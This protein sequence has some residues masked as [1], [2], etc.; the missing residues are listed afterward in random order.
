QTVG[1]C[2]PQQEGSFPSEFRKEGDAYE[3]HNIV[4]FIPIH[5]G[6]N[7]HRTVNHHIDK[8]EITAPVPQLMR[9]ISFN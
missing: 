4:R 6:D 9:L 2:P 5:I 7:R 1:G 8:K 3:L